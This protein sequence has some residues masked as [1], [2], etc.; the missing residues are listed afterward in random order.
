MYQ[1]NICTKIYKRAFNEKSDY[2][3]VNVIKETGDSIQK[4][5]SSINCNVNPLTYTSYSYG[6]VPKESSG[7]SRRYKLWLA[8]YAKDH[9]EGRVAQM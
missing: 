3:D 8:A 1:N 5:V 6:F 2:V 9:N 7:H 4:K